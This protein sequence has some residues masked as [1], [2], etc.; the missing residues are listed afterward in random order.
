MEIIIEYTIGQTDTETFLA[1]M[2]E[3]GRIRK[4]DGARR[5]SLTRDM[6]HPEQWMESYHLPTWLEYVRYNQRLTHADAIVGE[7]IRKLHAGAEPPKVLRMIERP[8]G[9]RA[10][11]AEPKGVLDLHQQG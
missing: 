2:A 5:W 11:D 7:E 3:R 9:R 10:W 8:T 6:E 1:M 4:R